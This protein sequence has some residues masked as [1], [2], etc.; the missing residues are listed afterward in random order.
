[1][2]AAGL[3]L[4]MAPA[5]GTVAANAVAFVICAIANAAANRRYTFAL[6]G[7]AGRSRHFTATLILGVVPLLLTTLVLVAFD[8]DSMTSLGVALLAVLVINGAATAL[9]FVLLRR[10]VYGADVRPGRDR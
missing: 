2:V 7:R 10:W 3:F 5:I 9:K 8:L 4:V 6:H 1:M